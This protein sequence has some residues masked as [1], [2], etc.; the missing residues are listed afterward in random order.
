SGTF[1][2]EL[3]L[4]ALKIGPGDEVILAAYD[5]PGN[6]LN[7]H[8][9]GAIPVLVDV[10]AGNCNLDAGLLEAA[11]RPATR[12]VIVSHLRDGMT[13][14]SQGEDCATAAG[15]RVREAA[16]GRRGAGGDGGKGGSG[17][18][19]AL[20]GFG[21]SMW[22]RAGGGAAPLTRHTDVHQRA[23]TLQF[24]GNVLAPL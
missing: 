12:A 24:R 11:V 7:I 21:G 20:Q 5:Y 14:L 4:R 23:R 1:A 6:F 15:L 17:G 22:H 3:A 2:V 13:P 19:A 16:R 9:V 8:A 18:D 10:A